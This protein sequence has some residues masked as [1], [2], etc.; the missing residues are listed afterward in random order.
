M[1]LVAVATAKTDS[2][3]QAKFFRLLGIKPTEQEA[4]PFG[5]LNVVVKA[6]RALIEEDTKLEFEDKGIKDLR[7]FE[8]LRNLEWLRLSHNPVHDLKPLSN[9]TNLQVLSLYGVPNQRGNLPRIRDL[10]PLANLVN[11][12]SLALDEHAIEDLSPLARLSNLKDLY[13]TNNQISQIDQLSSLLP[14]KACSFP[15][16]KSLISVLFQ[17]WKV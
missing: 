6:H 12:W 3:S 11:L 1:C 9:L 8:M 15:T 16:I 4:T 14:S 13:L 17:V 5:G 10:S 7:V 2:V